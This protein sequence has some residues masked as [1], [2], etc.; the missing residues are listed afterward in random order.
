MMS[1]HDHTHG[2]G[3][4][5]HGHDVNPDADRGKPAKAG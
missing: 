1:G 5:G 4:A 2:G 3:H